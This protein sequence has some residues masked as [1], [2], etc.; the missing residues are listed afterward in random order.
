MTPE[1]DFDNGD[2]LLICVDCEQDFLLTVGEQ[3][4]FESRQLAQPRRCKRC[5]E[6][7]RT[8]VGERVS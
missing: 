4:F 8:R 5:R 7:K 2:L 6:L 1:P 3:Q